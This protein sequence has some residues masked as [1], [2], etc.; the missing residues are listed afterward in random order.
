MTSNSHF[1]GQDRAAIERT[2]LAVLA[3]FQTEDACRA[4]LRRGKNVCLN[5]L[6]GYMC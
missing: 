2:Q 4:A 5:C 1:W 3:Q 6:T